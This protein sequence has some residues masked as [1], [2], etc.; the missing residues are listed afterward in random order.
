MIRLLLATIIRVGRK[1]LSF[2][3][4]KRIVDNGWHEKSLV[5]LGASSS[6]VCFKQ[7]LLELEVFDEQVTHALPPNGLFLTEVGYSNKLFNSE[8]TVVWEW[9]HVDSIFKTSF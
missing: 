1:D 6:R 3:E 8:P 4:F 2:Q 7:N 9:L 5:M